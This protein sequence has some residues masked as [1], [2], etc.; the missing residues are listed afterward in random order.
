MTHDTAPAFTPNEPLAPT[1]QTSPQG[2]RPLPCV[3]LVEHND[4]LALALNKWLTQQ[5]YACMHLRDASAVHDTLLSAQPALVLLDAALPDNTGY[6]ICQDIRTD[7]TLNNVPIVLMT[8]CCTA[9]EQRKAQALGATFLLTK[10]F[11]LHELA[12]ALNEIVPSYP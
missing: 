11:H 10:P 5:G 1:T 6:Q 3:L 9:L 4:H 2:Q 12:A 8:A 7:P